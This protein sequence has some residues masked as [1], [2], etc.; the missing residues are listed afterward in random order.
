[1]TTLPAA[2]VA[3][4]PAFLDD[5]RTTLGDDLVGVYLY[6]SAVAGGFDPA[7]S[8]FDVAVVVARPVDEIDL[9]VLDG[10]VQRLSS[11]EPAWADRL[12]IV[13][14]GRSTL[15]TFRSGG[16]LVS[17][18]HDEPLQRFDDADTWLQTWFLVRTADATVI[19]PPIDELILPIG[20]DE[21]VSAVT[22]DADRIVRRA[23]RP[24]SSDEL[25]AYTLLT[26]ARVAQVRDTG[27]VVPKDDAGRW[28]ASWMP[29][30]AGVI[31]AAIAVRHGGPADGAWRAG[32]RRLLLEVVP[33]GS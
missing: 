9:G 3:L 13:L 21:F 16:P 5:L 8:D 26:V 22:A 11:R 31:E 18:S 6:G 15:A 20:L 30:Q 25:L 33:F 23:M 17:I 12:D 14:V 29:Q 28:L 19:G 27:E 4:L 24:E 2:I 32:V 7:A 1:M 10:V